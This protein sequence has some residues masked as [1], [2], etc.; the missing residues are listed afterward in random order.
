[1][2]STLHPEHDWQPWK[3]SHT[4]R[5]FWKTTENVKRYFETL[6]Q[7]KSHQTNATLQLY[8]AGFYSSRR[9]SIEKYFGSYDATFAE[10]LFNNEKK[11]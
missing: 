9:R 4:S 1:M 7:E 3:F 11:Y 5:S 8:E 6:A 2:L 10:V